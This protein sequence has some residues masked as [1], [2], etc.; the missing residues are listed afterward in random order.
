[1][2]LV[3]MGDEQTKMLDKVLDW[4]C[5]SGII[6]GKKSNPL[7]GESIIPGYFPHVCKREDVCSKVG[8]FKYRDFY[9]TII[10]QKM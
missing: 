1:M 8:S 7:N 10:P 9:C 5:V 6:G 4:K 2:F 3:K